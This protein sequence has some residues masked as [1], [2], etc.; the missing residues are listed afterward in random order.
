MPA[1]RIV[2]AIAGV[3]I[4]CAGPA[5]DYGVKDG[6]CPGAM[7]TGSHAC[8]NGDSFECATDGQWVRDQTCGSLGCNSSKG[9][10]NLPHKC[11]PHMRFCGSGYSYDCD[12]D[13]QPA[14]A[15]ECAAGCDDNTGDCKPAQCSGTALSCGS[16]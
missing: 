3:V 2:S 4:G 8:Y 7:T 11:E 5:P 1:S 14:D 10:C 16:N 13:G 9:E 6:T 12:G 15:Q